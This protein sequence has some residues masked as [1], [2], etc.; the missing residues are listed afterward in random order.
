MMNSLMFSVLPDVWSSIYTS[1]AKLT[2]ALASSSGCGGGISGYIYRTLDLLLH[3][4]KSLPKLCAFL[5]FEIFFTPLTRS[6]NQFLVAFSNIV[7]LVRSF[8]ICCHHVPYPQFS[9]YVHISFCSQT[10]FVGRG[11]HCIMYHVNFLVSMVG[12]SIIYHLN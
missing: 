1:A 2:P 4:V 12:L 6:T 3:L 7:P 9:I 5:Q 8:N 11:Y 10:T